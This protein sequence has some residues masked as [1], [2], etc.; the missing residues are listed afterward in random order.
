MKNL[1]GPIRVLII[2]DEPDLLDV[3]TYLLTRE[4]GVQVVS[5]RS[6]READQLL[7]QQTFQLIVCDYHLTGETPE[8]WL[9]EQRFKGVEALFLIYTGSF[10]VEDQRY[11]PIDGALRTILKTDIRGLC[12]AL[13]AAK[14]YWAS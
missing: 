14:L 3:A 5:A 4:G 2:D 6:Y 12:E 1:E 10:D 13:K 7:T 8:G 9:M 11:P